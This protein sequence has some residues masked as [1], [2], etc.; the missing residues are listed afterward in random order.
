ME[1]NQAIS[2]QIQTV[3][4]KTAA[5]GSNASEPATV[6]PPVKD[7]CPALF[8]KAD[9]LYE[10]EKITRKDFLQLNDEEKDYLINK[11][12]RDANRLKGEEQEEF[13]ERVA[14]VLHAGFQDDIWET[15]HAN[16]VQAINKYIAK[17]GIMPRKSDLLEM[18]GV[19]RRTLY[20]HLKE[21]EHN[22]NYL[23][24]KDRYKLVSGKILAILYRE[25]SGGDMKAIKLFLEATG[26]INSGS[27]SSKN[28]VENQH[29]YIQINQT[30]LS[31][32]EIKK[33]RPDQLK[34]IEQILL[35]T[36][37]D[38]AR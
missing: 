14:P 22:P 7:I 38:T 10:Q 13:L 17:H 18:T 29:N 15:N 16:I 23:E 21:Y 3:S 2:Q 27:S 11:I 35:A 33:L 34:K 36:A 6:N 25:A 19:S 24:Q 12:N 30:R 26:A 1:T 28:Y 8:A 32:E 4:G 5:P 9:A 31:Q 20:K 37:E